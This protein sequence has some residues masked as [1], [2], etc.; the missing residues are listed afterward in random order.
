MEEPKLYIGS[1]AGCLLIAVA[2]LLAVMIPP[3]IRKH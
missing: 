3:H 1:L 2:C